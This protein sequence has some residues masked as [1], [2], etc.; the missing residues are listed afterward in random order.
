LHQHLVDALL[1]VDDE[2]KGDAAVALAREARVVRESVSGVQGEAGRAVVTDPEGYEPPV[3]LCDCPAETLGVELL[4]PVD[5]RHSERCDDLW[6][7]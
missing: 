1:G 6:T 2:R 3:V 7:H 4:C 5:V